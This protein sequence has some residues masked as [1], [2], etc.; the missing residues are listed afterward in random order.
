MNTHTHTHVYWC[1]APAVWNSLPK[2]VVNSDSVTVFKSR[3]KTFLFSRAFSFSLLS[4]TLPGPSTSEVMTLW[5]YI[6]MFYYYYTHTRLRPF[7]PVW[8]N[9]AKDR[10]GAL[11][12]KLQEIGTNWTQLYS[13]ARQD[14]SHAAGLIENLTGRRCHSRSGSASGTLCSCWH[15]K[16]LLHGTQQSTSTDGSLTVLHRPES[17]CWVETGKSSSTKCRPHKTRSKNFD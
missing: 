5:H 12:A 1:S 4:N 15:A 16:A 13:S 7:F 8:L 10:K 9:T 6:N 14:F 17:R 11:R 3:L 2:T